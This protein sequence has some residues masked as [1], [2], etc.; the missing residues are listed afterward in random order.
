MVP[1]G[2]RWQSK[3]KGTQ[4]WKCGSVVSMAEWAEWVVQ[5]G[6]SSDGHGLLHCQSHSLILK[7]NGV[8]S[9]QEKCV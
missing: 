6:I 2:V 1:R 8:A 9:D 7:Q 4:R 5:L 3:W